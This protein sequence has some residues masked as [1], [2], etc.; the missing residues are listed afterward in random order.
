MNL[1]PSDS[2]LRLQMQQLDVTPTSVGN[3]SPNPFAAALGLGVVAL[4][5]WLLFVLGPIIR[6]LVALGRDGVDFALSLS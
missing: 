3:R 5:V 4:L 6:Q 2:Q 1:R